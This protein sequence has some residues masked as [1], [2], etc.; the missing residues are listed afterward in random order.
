MLCPIRGPRSIQKICDQVIRP[1]FPRCYGDP[2]LDTADSVAQVMHWRVV[3]LVPLPDDTDPARPAGLPGWV[4]TPPET[5]FPAYAELPAYGAAADDDRAPEHPVFG[6]PSQRQLMLSTAP[7]PYADVDEHGGPGPNQM[8]LLASAEPRPAADDDAADSSQ[9]AL[10]AASEPHRQAD[11]LELGGWLADQAARIVDRIRALAGRAAGPAPEWTADLGPL[12]EDLLER[13]DW[14]DRAGQ[15]AAY[16]ERYRIPDGDS[17]LLGPASVRGEQRRARQWVLHYLYSGPQR[18]P[19]TVGGRGPRPTRRRADANPARNFWSDLRGACAGW[20]QHQ[21][22]EWVRAGMLDQAEDLLADPAW[23][24]LAARLHEVEQKGLDVAATLA[25]TAAERE[26]G[27][28]DSVAQ[29][30]HY[31]L[32]EAAAPTSFADTV[33]PS[34]SPLTDGARAFRDRLA[35]AGRRRIDEAA[36]DPAAPDD[37]AAGRPAEP[38]P[39]TPAE[40]PPLQRPAP[41]AADAPNFW[42]QLADASTAYLDQ[43]EPEPADHA[44]AAEP[45]RPRSAP[46]RDRLA[47]L[48]TRLDRPANT[49]AEHD[50]GIRAADPEHDPLA[51]E[52][53]AE[54]RRREQQLADEQYHQQDYGR[55]EG[56]DRG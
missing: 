44:A 54:Q 24:A 10:F 6:G 42:A 52:Q 28:A 4:S 7:D 35:E 12:S 25:D 48:R 18:E 5:S 43:A 34:A 14:L 55:D 37:A 50:T 36:A 53:E 46:L 47:A 26:L 51:A 29:V 27:T 31:R 3:D 21:A 56:I 11:L 40:A 13:E 32:A 49:G 9:P 22:A 33:M 16:R 30:M 1:K 17:R 45:S 39:A 15:V 19:V 8:L 41:I 23:S 38:E 2:E 20:L